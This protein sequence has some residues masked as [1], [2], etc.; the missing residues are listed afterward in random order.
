[1][2]KRSESWTGGGTGSG[3]DGN[4]FSPHIGGSGLKKPE[5]E[6]EVKV[7]SIGVVNAEESDGSIE[8]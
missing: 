6:D 1:M 7:G 2:S 3:L 4:S 8:R 5:G